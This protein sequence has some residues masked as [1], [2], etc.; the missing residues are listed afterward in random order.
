[1]PKETFYNLDQDKKSKITEVLI[2]EFSEK[3]F[4]KVS[5]KA[6]VERL[7]IARGSFYQYFEDLE[8]SY[9]YILD[10]KT[11]DMHI[12][13]MTS[14]MKN[15]GDIITSLN[16]FGL[17]IADIIFKDDCY[18]LYKNRFLFWNESLNEDWINCHQNYDKV[19]DKADKMNIDLEKIYFFRAVVHSLVER[20]FREE[21]DKVTFI[22]KYK[23]HMDW[24]KKGIFDANR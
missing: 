18:N 5:V 1:M 6:I 24:I 13:F 17:N 3:P 10:K 21:W 15:D 20:N 8:D 22:E 7:G 4:E 2:S 14:L 12:L 23:I 16:D 9:F 11:H 19:F